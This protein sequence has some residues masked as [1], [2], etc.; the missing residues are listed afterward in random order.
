MGAA[1]GRCRSAT[2]EPRGRLSAYSCVRAATD[3]GSNGACQRVGGRRV[4]ATVLE[5]VFEAL[6]PASLQATAKALSE[7][8]AESQRR[9]VAFEAAVE[10]AGYEAERARRQFEAVEPENRLVARGLESAWETRLIELRRAPRQRWP[11]SMEKTLSLGDEELAWLTRAGA[12]LRAVFDAETTTT[13]ERKQLLRTILSEVMI[14][15][16]PE[17]KVAQLGICASASRGVPSSAAA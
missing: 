16:D 8:E 14:T 3:I 4:D 15:L 6:E 7:A 12:D 1:G 17:T 11:P 9:L 5:A 10:R 2:G 13:A